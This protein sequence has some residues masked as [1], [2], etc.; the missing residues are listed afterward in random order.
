MEWYDY[1]PLGPGVNDEEE[2]DL[3]SIWTFED[4]DVLAMWT[5]AWSDRFDRLNPEEV[6]KEELNVIPVLSTAQPVAR[7]VPDLSETI[8]KLEKKNVS[9]AKRI[10]RFFVF[11]F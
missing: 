2:D 5:A 3:W 4:G 9:V 1:F 11:R 7:E 8:V 10:K 6:V